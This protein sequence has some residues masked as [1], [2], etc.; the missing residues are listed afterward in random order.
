MSKTYKK[1][2]KEEMDFISNN[3]KTMKDEEIASYL[4]KID[5]SRQI[6]VGMIR[7]QRRKLLISKPRGRRPSTQQSQST[8]QATD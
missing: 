8:V 7:R 1:W 6:S 4:S 3:S 5:S 2:T